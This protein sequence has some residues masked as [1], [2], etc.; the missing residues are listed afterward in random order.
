MPA[1]IAIMP[2]TIT[3]IPAR[4]AAVRLP[5]KPMRRIAGVPMIVRVWRQ[6]VKAHIG[7]VV[8]ACDSEAIADAITAEGGEAVLTDPNLPSGSDRVA[9]ALNEID[10]K[11]KFESVINL[12]GDV[13]EV[14]PNLLQTLAAGMAKSDL[15][16]L[17]LVAPLAESDIAQPQV[18]KVAIAWRG[19]AIGRAL[20]FSRS[21]IPYGGADMWHHIGIY[22]W[23]RQA[24]QQFISLPPSPLELSEKLEQLRA[25]EAG[26]PIGVIAVDSP[27]HGIDT[28]D[29]LLA[30]EKRMAADDSS[31]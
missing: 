18:V 16:L 26:L 3:I 17:T 11:G 24:L 25:M 20:Y 1:Q 13:P 6:A 19:E 14:A 30:A 10:P 22:G 29:D 23:R 2:D 28:A 9:A 15:P 8:V 21:P 7:P 27:P 5:N 31:G 12:Q 4:M